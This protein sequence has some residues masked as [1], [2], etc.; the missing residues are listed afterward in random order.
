MKKTVKKKAVR[1]KRTSNFIKLPWEEPGFQCGQG[2]C[3]GEA[4]YIS[5][6]GKFFCGKCRKEYRK[7]EACK[8]CGAKL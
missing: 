4:R 8:S 3:E 2:K 6:D 1:R 5:R 7:P